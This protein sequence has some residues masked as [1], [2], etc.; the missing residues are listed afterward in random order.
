MPTRWA[1]YRYP[2]NR[3]VSLI[4]GPRATQ[5][6][7]LEAG[8]YANAGDGRLSVASGRE[9][10]MKLS[11]LLG[12]AYRVSAGQCTIL[13]DG[14]E[15]RSYSAAMFGESGEGWDRFLI[16]GD[17]VQIK[18][19]YGE[20]ET[21][22][23]YTLSDFTASGTASFQLDFEFD[24]KVFT[25]DETVAESLT[26]RALRFDRSG[27]TESLLYFYGEFDQNGEVYT[28]E[29][30]AAL[31]FD[32]ELTDEKWDSGSSAIPS[33]GNIPSIPSSGDDDCYV[34]GGTGRIECPDCGGSGKE[35]C[36]SCRGSGGRYVT[37]FSSPLYDGV[38][39][40]GRD[41]VWKE[42]TSCWGDGE[43]DCSRC[44]GRGEV[45]C[46]AC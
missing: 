31:P 1:T 15:V 44:Y 28:V 39:S 17:D 24:Y 30:L 43:D 18:L 26:F 16:E 37:D 33:G 41:K 19:P 5:A 45:D 35:V 13:V 29:G 42:C 22:D 20:L 46:Y 38:G 14:T 25:L 12:A 32:K 11:N 2:D 34:C 23:V 10:E 21:G 7:V 9:G 36:S 4:S 40:D 3:Q 27:K 8:A 6:Y